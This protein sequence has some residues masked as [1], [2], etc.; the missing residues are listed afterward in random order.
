MRRSATPPLAIRGTKMNQVTT[1]TKI[2]ATFDV[3]EAVISLDTAM[4]LAKVLDVRNTSHE[5]ETVFVDATKQSQKSVN[6][7]M[8]QDKM[9]L[10]EVARKRLKRFLKQGLTPEEA[11]REAL[12]PIKPEGT[13]VKRP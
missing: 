7:L 9:R 8:L 12:K 1:P 4:E 10:I 3:S 2:D 13:G 5:N 6:R 11:L